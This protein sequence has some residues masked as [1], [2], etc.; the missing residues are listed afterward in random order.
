MRGSISG[1]SLDTHS[2]GSGGLRGLALLYYA[3]LEAVALQTKQIVRE[4]NAKGNKTTGEVGVG[5]HNVRR[6]Y[7]SGSQAKNA[8]LMQLLADACYEESEDEDR[9]LEGVVVARSDAEGYDNDVK[10]SLGLADEVSLASGREEKGKVSGVSAVVL[11]AAMLGR[12]ADELVVDEHEI[13]DQ[14]KAEILWDIM[15]SNPM[16]D[17]HN[18]HPS[19]NHPSLID[20]DDATRN[21]NSTIDPLC[22]ISRRTSVEIEGEKGPGCKVRRLHGHD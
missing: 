16:L 19:T 10:L 3:T 18:E 17:H 4:L 21:S 22:A 7:V 9:R 14:R 8:L 1:L 13:K 5:G 6:L 12:M 11:G 20:G 15:V 2:S